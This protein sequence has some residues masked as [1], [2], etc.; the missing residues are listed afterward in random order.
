VLLLD[1]SL[2]RLSIIY[3]RLPESRASCCHVALCPWWL[4]RPYFPRR[5]T[6]M[7]P[8]GA[9]PLAA[10]LL[11]CGLAHVGTPRLC[12]PMRW[13]PIPPRCSRDLCVIPQDAVFNTRN[14]QCPMCDV[15]PRAP[16]WWS[17][18]EVLTPIVGSCKNL[19]SE[20]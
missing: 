13:A 2:W 4:P 20:I 15:M 8:C 17:I 10:P 7:L 14:T 6:P 18:V 16:V 1:S 12:R 3:L 9:T 11:P 5:Q 19:L